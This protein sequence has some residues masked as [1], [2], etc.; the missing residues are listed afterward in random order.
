MDNFANAIPWITP[1]K[2]DGNLKRAA[3]MKQNSTAK[4]KKY[5]PEEIDTL[6]SR[7]FEEYRNMKKITNRE[8]VEVNSNSIVLEDTNKLPLNIVLKNQKSKPTEEVSKNVDSK[9]KNRN[10]KN[11]Q[12]F[13]ANNKRYSPAEIDLLFSSYF[14]EYKNI[15]TINNSENSEVNTGPKDTTNILIK[16]QHIGCILQSC[17][18]FSRIRS[19]NPWR[20]F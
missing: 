13:K 6:F 3:K 19:Q 15:K 1:Q 14:E 12:S 17:V 16:R 10:R 2:Q 8:H 11:K 18:Y 20:K 7:C 4:K 9:L 5:S